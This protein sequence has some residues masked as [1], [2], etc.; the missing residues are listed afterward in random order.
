ML[1]IYWIVNLQAALKDFWCTTVKIVNTNRI[2]SWKL[3]WNMSWAQE[4]LISKMQHKLWK[5]WAVHPYLHRINFLMSH[6]LQEIFLGLFFQRLFWKSSTNNDVH[7][8]K[9]FISLCLNFH[10]PYSSQV[11]IKGQEISE[12]K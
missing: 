8:A 10:T 11:S 3:L 5:L 1:V 2:W 12:W 7:G 4:K 9:T 6:V